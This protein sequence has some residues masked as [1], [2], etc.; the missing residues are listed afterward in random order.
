MS[1][2]F[3]R[4]TTTSLLWLSGIWI[5]TQL[6]GIFSPPLLDDMD[7]LH[8]EAAREMVT[9]HHYV[10]LY[11]DGIRYLD[12]SPLPYWLGA[13]SI[14]IFGVHDWA[15][16]LPLALSMLTLIV[17]IYYFARRLYGERAGFYAGCVMAT[18]VGPYVFTRFFIPDVIVA[19]W[20]TIAADAAL[21]MIQSVQDKGRAEAWQAIVFACAIT[22]GL[23]TKG[24]IGLV[25]PVG[26]L[27]VYLLCVRKLHYLLRMRLLLCLG[28]MLATALPWH[29][30]A[31]IRNPASGQAN[32]WLW[33]Y[34][35]NE[36][37]NRYLNKRIPR[38]YD[39]VPLVRFWLLL[40]AWL[41]PW[42]VFLIG[43]VRNL[44]RDRSRYATS[45]KLFLVV[46]AVLI[47]LFFSFST[48]QG[49]YTLPAVPALALLIGVFLAREE[50]QAD[51]SVFWGRLSSYILFAVGLCIALPCAYFGLIAPSPPKGKELYQALTEHPQYYARAL[52]HLHDLTT[53]AMGYFRGPL[54]GMAIGTFLGTGLALWL[55]LRRKYYAANLILTLAMCLVLASVHSAFK[56]FYPILGSKP[57]A[58]AINKQFRPG[59]RIVIDGQ[60]SLASS[61]GFYTRQPLYM[62]NG[63]VN[64]L[65]YG[66]LFADA[67]HRF[68]ND[69]SFAK[70]W[71]GPTRIF[72]VTDS[73]EDAKKLRQSKGAYVVAV[74]AGKSVLSNRPG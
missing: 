34:F 46:W 5:V 35:V 7:A 39:K 48:R 16:R 74:Y 45:P 25:F 8:V 58:V 60:Y 13:F 72:F 51:D 70:L 63:R 10:T 15:V 43:T 65:W 3:D 50:R 67:P 36:Q 40:F 23:L 59:D 55:R 27:F 31:A 33:F 54:I 28:V 44:W 47:P 12:K 49:Y 29:I 18:C 69:A 37:F 17:Y 19:L 4:K 6:V 61:V 9:R 21:R 14:H 56:T 30:L 38:D 11:V 64:N 2:R 66:S 68:E 1:L 42:G 71:S 52:G 41:L 57:L 20:L 53:S 62:L 22:L 26:I 32:G 73:P 24:L